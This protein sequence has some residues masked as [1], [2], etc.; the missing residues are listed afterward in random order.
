[1]S[2]MAGA[3]LGV[4]ILLL[5]AAYFAAAPWL[6]CAVVLPFWH[7]DAFTLRVCTF[8][9]VAL[10]SGYGL[11]GFA[12]PHWGNLAVGILYVIAAIFVARRMRPL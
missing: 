5:V 7:V 4:V 2:I 12:G 10:R 3:R 8:G 1:M 6:G 9:D 11:P